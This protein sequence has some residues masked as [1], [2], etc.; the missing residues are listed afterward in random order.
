MFAL[1][2]RTASGS[3]EMPSR[4]RGG[5]SRRGSKSQTPDGR[6]GPRDP[7][8]PSA[9]DSTA[10]SCE[11]CKTVFTKE[12]SK[13]LVCDYCDLFFCTA[14]IKVS[15]EQYDIMA[16]IPG[17]CWFC[18]DCQR[19]ARDC[20]K[21]EKQIEERC[22]EYCKKIEL[23]LTNV[24]AGLS[25]KVSKDDVRDIVRTE[26]AAAPDNELLQEEV[27]KVSMAVAEHQKYLESME[28]KKRE[29]NIIMTG[30]SENEMV[31]NGVQLSTDSDKCTA[32]L[33]A[34]GEDSSVVRSISR[35]G[36]EPATPREG[37]PRIIKL[38]LESSECRS[39]ILKKSKNLK[40]AGP[41]FSRIYM[42]KDMHPMVNR[43]FQRLKKVTKE[44]KEKP[45]NQGREVRYDHVKRQVLVD[46]V[47]VDEFHPTFF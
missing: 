16:D 19:K 13:L 35:L 12:D 7:D 39:R 31:V 8:G 24:E 3:G 1:F 42:K 21:T 25:E 4:P 23:R 22:S 26:L 47:A 34:V 28:A 2:L 14:C 40:E 43:E 45:E 36:K 15:D 38:Q 29:L 17:T 11:S 46:G 37:H 10:W 5:K 41:S 33:Q 27:R 20:I 6:A 9:S 44:E 30:V 18:S 32:V